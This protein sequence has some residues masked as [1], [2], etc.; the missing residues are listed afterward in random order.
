MT[1]ILLPNGKQQYFTTAGLP[2]VGYKVATFAAG[3]STP[4]VTWQDALKVAQNTN[5]V[6]LDGRGEA[7]IFWDGAYKVQL[8]D[9]SGT[10]I[11]TQD[12]LQSQQNSITSTL[13]PATNNAVD[14]GSAALSWRNG[15]FAT[16]ILLGPNNAPAFDAVSGNIGYYKQT[17]AEVAAG[18]SPPNLVY[19]PGDLRRYGCDVTGATD[20][21]A[22]INSA[23]LAA[24]ASG[25]VGYI[26]HPG[27]T[28]SHA[29]QISVPNNLS[30]LGW[31]RAAC[32][33]KFTG[34]P[35]GSPTY[36]RSAWRYAGPNVTPW[37]GYANVSFK[38]VQLFYLNAVN[39]AAAL[40]LNAYGM[41]YF[42]V[43]DCWIKG[44]CSYGVI[45][46][47]VELGWVHNN[48]IE[49]TNATSNF[50]IWVVNGADRGFTAGIGFSNVLSIRENQISG[51]A[52]GFGLIDDGGNAHVV[53][54]N[55]FN[56]H[57]TQAIFAGVSGLKLGG[58]SFENAQSTQNAS[59]NVRFLSASTAGNPV[60][61][62]TGFEI[63]ANGFFG[64]MSAAGAAMLS[65]SGTLYSISGITLA[66]SGVITFSSAAT[67]NP[68][69]V[70]QFIYISGVIGMTQIN[71]KSVQV[72]SIGGVAG[73]WTATVQLNTSGFSAYASG[74][75]GQSMHAG[76][77]VKGNNFASVL[78]RGTAIDVTFL[79]NSECSSNFDSGSA[80]MFH[81][82]GVHND[83]VGN[84]LMP[85][86]NGALPVLNITGPTYGDLRFPSL[87]V[88]GV[89]LNGQLNPA[90]PALGAQ[91]GSVYQG[92]GVPSNANGNN[93]DMYFRT[94][95]PGTA[96]QRLYVKSAGAWIGI[97]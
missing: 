27:G 48:L 57:A 77:F 90:T 83:N 19:P 79:A 36:T 47:G 59:A 16:N 54:G 42:E 70:G 11:W 32:I 41:S 89:S 33:F 6:I 44:S 5:P 92:I 56:G 68:F 49:N 24:V 37:S 60:G 84:L 93:G 80:S 46:D 40:E 62:C 71:G 10:P 50:N 38:H 15:Y 78:G 13:L 64:N 61:P 12:N 55:N 7:S 26:W 3:T 86:Q 14:L 76:G 63:T 53:Q 66:A 67:A 94:D 69:V 87:I 97:L 9:A 20:N 95:T 96:N 8:Q 34:T 72:N 35:S 74:G 31:S 85:P 30:V 17:P 88:G 73:A 45:L 23:I 91:S 82:N 1:A 58:N 75:Q 43:E 4:Q 51:S 65:F 39:F 52:T 28:I 29:S 21:T 22:Q 18:V 2:A 81:Y 25:G